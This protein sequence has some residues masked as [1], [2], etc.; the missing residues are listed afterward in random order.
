MR[1]GCALLLSFDVLETFEAA[2][3]G[4]PGPVIA[5]SHDRW[6]IRGFGGNVWELEDGRIIHHDSPAAYLARWGATNRAAA[7]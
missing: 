5:A 6:F 7:P 1:A 4:F 3:L 2:V